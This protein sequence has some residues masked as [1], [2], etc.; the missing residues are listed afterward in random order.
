MIVKCVKLGGK[1][2]KKGQKRG[3]KD[4][5]TIVSINYNVVPFKSRKCSTMYMFF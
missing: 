1:V 5:D 2:V 3:K 4:V